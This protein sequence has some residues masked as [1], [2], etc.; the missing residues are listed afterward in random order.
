M[1]QIVKIAVTAVLVLEAMASLAL[2]AGCLAENALITPESFRQTALS[3][4]WIEGVK[5]K[6]RQDF[7]P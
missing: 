2:L 4:G 3:S 5:E 1:K 6:I 7:E